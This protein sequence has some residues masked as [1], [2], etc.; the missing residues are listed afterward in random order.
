MCKF[1]K[2]ILNLKNNHSF[3]MPGHNK[4]N[5]LNLKNLFFLDKTEHI[6]TGNLYENNFPI[7]HIQHITAKYYNAKY[8]YL[9]TNGA[10]ACILTLILSYVGQNGILIADR[11]CHKSIINA[12]TLFN[13]TVF[14][15]DNE[16]I[17]FYDIT[18][19]ITNLDNILNKITKKYKNKKKAIIITNP[20]YY[21]III[22]IKNLLSISKK[23]NVPLI[24]DQSHAAHF[25]A[26]NIKIDV[27]FGAEASV[28]SMHKTLPCL[29]QSA[30]ILTNKKNDKLMYY[31]SLFSTSSPSYLILSSMEKAISYMNNIGNKKYENKVIQSKKLIK[32]ISN[33]TIF[34]PLTNIDYNIDPLRLTISCKNT[35][36]TS[37]YIF[38][39]LY[40]KYN[41]EAEMF[42]CNNIIFILAGINRKFDILLNALKS[43]KINNNF[44]EKKIN[45]KKINFKK[46]RKIP[47]ITKEIQIK[48]DKAIGKICSR[49]YIIYPPGTALILPGQIIQKKHIMIIK[50]TNNSK[51]LW[52][53]KV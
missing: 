44:I 42:D 6:E 13:I 9:S 45:F 3:C 20:T 31:M 12:I 40:K 2:K 18:G 34:T 17:D 22:D 35:G 10:T 11:N 23:Y 37:N 26:L 28:I 14:F 32:K 48:I 51:T 16:I 43:F 46:I 52:V 8:S 15:T 39:E 5:I 49:P 50:E 21:G 53:K 30:L 36:Y 4:K 41:V 7:K 1:I 38:N 25:P 47:L 27:C 24:V 19:N 33:E 29:T